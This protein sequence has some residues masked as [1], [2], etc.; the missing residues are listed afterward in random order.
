VIKSTNSLRQGMKM[1]RDQEIRLLV[2]RLK[3]EHRMD[4]KF[5][6]NVDGYVKCPVCETG[7]IRYGING[8]TWKSHGWCDTPGCLEWRE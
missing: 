7:R 1:D 3:R 6:R 5:H 4:K 8:W 2:S